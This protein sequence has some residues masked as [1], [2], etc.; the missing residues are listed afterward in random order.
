MQPF[1]LA[2][3]TAAALPSCLPP[4]AAAYAFPAH[5]GLLLVRNALSAEQQRLLVVDA[6]TLFPEPPAH[7]NHTRAL[8][9][10]SGLWAAAQAGLRL[11]LERPASAGDADAAGEANGCSKKQGTVDRKMSGSSDHWAADGAGPPAATLLRKLRWAAL[12]PPFDWTVREYLRQEA[13]RP[14]PASLSALATEL[15]SLA[16]QLLGAETEGGITSPSEQQ[17]QQQQPAQLAAQPKFDA[18][19]VNFYY[20]GSTLGGHVDDAEADLTKPLVALSLGCPAVFL[21]GGATRDAPPAALL[22]RSGDA[23]VMAGPAR[24][25]YH[26]VP[27]VFTDA[28]APALTV[29]GESDLFA[30]FAAHMHTCRINIS[31]R[32]TC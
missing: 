11:R 16:G 9:G 18:A 2:A 27:R 12:G 5:P 28:P 15:A 10:L 19:L 17:Q 30:P 22:L 13:H 24:R 25:A 4:C 20:E 8:G 26:G 21:A 32:E 1:D 29:S 23:V 7:T 14:L 3:A 31:I 6:L